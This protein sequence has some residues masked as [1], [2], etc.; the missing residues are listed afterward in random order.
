M[1]LLFF[2]TEEFGVDSMYE[3]TQLW[4]DFWCLRWWLVLSRVLHRT[5]F[6]A[7]DLNWGVSSWGQ[8]LLCWR[9]LKVNLDKLYEILRKVQLYETPVCL[10]IRNQ[11]FCVGDV[12]FYFCRNTARKLPSLQRAVNSSWDTK[13]HGADA[14]VWCQQ[15]TAKLDHP[16][17]VSCWRF[18]KN[19]DFSTI[20]VNQQNR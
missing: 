2:L 13:L 1:V 7:C 6:A 17:C 20:L 16:D 12:W 18:S 15:K 3:I 19:T 4:L 8:R 9:D 14:V 5:S 11:C 10:L